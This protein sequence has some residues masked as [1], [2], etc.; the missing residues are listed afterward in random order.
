MASE[1]HI[2]HQFDAE[3]EA[4]KSRVLAMGGIV[5]RQIEDAVVA[6]IDAD[7]QRAEEVVAREKQVNGLEV[8][9]D[10]EATKILVKR[11]PAASDGTSRSA[12]IRRIRI[13]T[14][15]PNSSEKPSKVK[16]NGHSSALSMLDPRSVMLGPWCRLFHHTTL[17]LMIGRLTAPTRA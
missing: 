12:M 13:S 4:I 10:D 15:A 14:M 3:L 5:E 8:A 7:S 16:P 11:Q 17:R 9:V 1:H 6:I 2:S